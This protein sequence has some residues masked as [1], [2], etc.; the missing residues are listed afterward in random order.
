[1]K[2][3]TVSSPPAT[4]P[5]ANAMPRAALLAIGLAVLASIVFVA[6]VRLSGADIREPDGATL[7]ERALRFEDGPGGSVIAI[8]AA[9]GRQAAQFT[10]EQGFLRGAL[11]ALARERKRVG[12]G[13]EQPFQ[14]VLR[15]DNRLTLLDPVTGQRIDLESFGP[16]NAGLFAGLLGRQAAPSR[17]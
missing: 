7:A 13:S 1:M 16:T 14:L 8:D 15:A 11:R 9:S 3:A 10:G 12:A 2:A 5:A 4:L 17:P 6:M